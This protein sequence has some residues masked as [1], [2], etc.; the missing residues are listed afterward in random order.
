MRADD[1]AKR[2]VAEALKSKPTPWLWIGPHSK[3]VWLI[4]TFLSRNGFVCYCTSFHFWLVSYC[5]IVRIPCY[6]GCLA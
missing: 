4:S 3:Q 1:W 6:Q 5:V 2:V